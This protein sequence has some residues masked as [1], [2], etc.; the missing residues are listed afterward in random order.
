MWKIFAFV[1]VLPSFKPTP[2]GM[3][4]MMLVLF[5]AG[6]GVGGFFWGRSG[7]SQSTQTPPKSEL[8]DDLEITKAKSRDPKSVVAYLK[9]NIPI[10]RQ[11][12][13]DY[14]IDRLGVDRIE[15]MVNRRIIELACRERNI[16]V[17]DAEVE[18]QLQ[19]DL[20]A[21][22]AKNITEKEFAVTILKR[23]NKS[24][25]EW[26]E[27]VIRPRIAMNKLVRS[28]ITVDETDLQRAY[29]TRYGPRVE[30]RMIVMAKA[31][32]AEA[33]KQL[34]EKVHS[35][36]CTGEEAF[37]RAATSRDIQ[38]IDVLREKGGKVPAIH[39]HFGDASI[40][41]AAFSLRKGEV[42]HV[43]EMPD[44][45]GVIIKCD[46]QVEGFKNAPS[47]EQVRSSLYQ[48]VLQLKI[49]M[50]VPE[51]MAQLRQ[52][53]AP[54]IYLKEQTRSSGSSDQLAM[55]PV[56]ETPATELLPP[57]PAALAPQSEPVPPPPSTMPDIQPTPS[58]PLEPPPAA[59][60]KLD[61]A[62]ASNAAAS[63]GSD[64]L[65]S[66]VPMVGPL[67]PAGAGPSGPVPTPGTPSV[68][69]NGLGY[70]IWPPA[71]DGK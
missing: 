31:P 68:L 51:K 3:R 49:N 50:S 60:M 24:L 70:P 42:S 43:M 11:E 21:L 57:P 9:G 53:W 17:S 27:D 1:K 69:G 58:V 20:N 7:A 46:E 44:G 13:G 23:F 41:R 55:L 8:F 67:T 65:R 30:C 59:A 6:V 37:M 64:S 71:K 52:Q 19:D 26:K 35:E 33:R 29:E 10:T 39:K 32:S 12:L 62:S 54:R 63:Q 40:E 34:W 14:L 5:I 16:F 2:S 66:V 56:P 48:E 61:P 47:M 18:A 22:G 25:F 4:K 45:T 36:V 28:E 15:A 38:C